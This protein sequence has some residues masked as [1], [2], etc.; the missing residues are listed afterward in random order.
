[1]A[2]FDYDI[3]TTPDMRRDEMPAG[4]GGLFWALVVLAVLALFVLGSMFAGGGSI[5]DPATAGQP[6]AQPE[7]LPTAPAASE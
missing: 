3:K 1:M 6:A 7:A 4:S 2:N 5:D